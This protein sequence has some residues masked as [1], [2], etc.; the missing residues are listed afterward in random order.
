MLALVLCHPCCS[1]TIECL[2]ITGESMAIVE[3]TLP[4]ILIKYTSNIGTLTTVISMQCTQFFR[5]AETFDLISPLDLLSKARSI[6]HYIGHTPACSYKHSKRD[7]LF[8][9]R[10][11]IISFTI[12]STMYIRSFIFLNAD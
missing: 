4:N 6:K 2:G 3:F 1:M 8:L 10:E 12:V 7:S 5:F 11:Y 9:L